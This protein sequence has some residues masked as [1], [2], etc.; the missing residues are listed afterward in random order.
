MTNIFDYFTKETPRDQQQTI[1]EKIQSRWNDYDVFVVVAP[2]ATGKTDIAVTIARWQ[3]AQNKTTTILTP[4]NVLVEQLS[5]SYPQYLSVLQRK[6]AYVCKDMN[7]NCETV[8]NRCK[9]RCKDCVYDKAKVDVEDGT[10]RLMNYHTYMSSQLRG[11]VLILDESHKLLDILTDQDSIK[12]WRDKYNWPENAKTVA[13]IMSWMESY[14]SKQRDPFLEKALRQLKKTGTETLIEHDRQFFRGNVSHV[15]K[16]RPMTLHNKTLLRSFMR[17]KKVIMMSATTNMQDIKDL[18][19]ENK[20]VL[21]IEVGSPIPPVNRKVFVE[22]VAN[23]TYANYDGAIKLIA[24]RIQTLLDANPSKGL[25]HLPYGLV[26]RLRGEINHP[27]L[28]FHNKENKSDALQ[29]F[30]D[31]EDGVLVASGL[32]EG[33]DLPYDSARWQVIAKVPF[34]SLADPAVKLRASKDPDWYAYQAI[35]KILQAIGRVC[36]APDDYGVT[37]IL[38][39]QFTR[40]YRTNQKLWPQ[41]V[42][43]AV[44]F[45]G[46][47]HG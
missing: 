20:R 35:R 24:A 39:T 11:D 6:A 45:V 41:Y 42:Q 14:L 23:V 31:S 25:I 16:L 10:I 4:T 18:G 47:N 9:R 1:L 2:T 38:D 36:R 7:M 22:P 8:Q 33:I 30:R 28:M 5:M 17:A 15:L 44:K 43:Q 27:R 21:L 29:R 34:L 32:Y 3:Q 19:M 40:L 46:G 37:Y 12:I 26:E 13:D